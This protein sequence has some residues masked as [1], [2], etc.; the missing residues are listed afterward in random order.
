MTLHRSATLLGNTCSLEWKGRHWS[1]PF[2]VVLRVFHGFSPCN[3][4]TLLVRTSEL[5]RPADYARSRTK[6][7]R[8]VAPEARASEAPTDPDMR[9]S[10]IRLFGPRLRYA[11]VAGRMCGSGS[12]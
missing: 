5:P 2:V 10:R 9:I 6:F 12:G 11:T 3:V 4:F 1:L 7:Y 8:R